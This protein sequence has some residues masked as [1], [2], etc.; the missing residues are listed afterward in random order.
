MVV[1]VHCQQCGREFSVSGSRFAH[2]R[3]RFCSKECFDQHRRRDRASHCARCGRP[4]PQSAR[5]ETRYCSRE[6]VTAGRKAGVTRTCVVCGASF[7]S[8][9]SYDH[10]CSTLCKA[11]RGG[12]RPAFEDPWA[13]GD[14]PPDRYARDLYRAAD[15]VLGF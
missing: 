10:T 3:G 8:V 7:I 12:V 1:N 13:C 5:P 9:S 2:G 6:C 11:M 4:M 15:P 14:I